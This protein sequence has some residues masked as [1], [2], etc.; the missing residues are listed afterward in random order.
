LLAGA[1]TMACRDRSEA[2]PRAADHA[3]QVLAAIERA[4]GL[5]FVKRGD[6]VLLKVNTNSGDPFPY[7]T[8][9][10]TVK[11]IAGALIAAG[12]KVTVGDRSFWGDDDT[13]GNLEAN[14]IAGATREA[15]AKLVV[16][17]R[18]EW[19]EIDP[20]LVPHWK[21][22]FRLPRIAVEAQHVINL[23]C[24]KTH[25]ISGV[26]L[27]LKN[28]LG[29]V[30]AEDRARPGNLRSHDARLIHHQIAD[31]NRALATRF[32]VIDGYRSLISGGPTRRD[33]SPAIADLGVVLAGRERVAL[34]VAA[35]ALLQKHAPRSEA[36]HRTAPDK[37][38]TILAAR[39]GGIA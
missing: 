34:D 35:I 20:K 38:P 19:V 28:M 8:S 23:A 39:A 30:H 11:A 13:A 9:P 12:A 16:F 10:V 31:V 21:P 37:H 3:K 25:F 22:P 1:A 24:A 26:T 14:G 15:G 17:D 7:S 36:V 4:G 2:A 5:G 18:V 27:G 6:R 33:G 29:L 32:T